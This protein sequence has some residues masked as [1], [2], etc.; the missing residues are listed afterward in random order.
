MQLCMRRKGSKHSLVCNSS[1]ASRLVPGRSKADASCAEEQNRQIGGTQSDRTTHEQVPCWPQRLCCL[2]RARPYR[3]RSAQSSALSLPRSPR[4]PD[5]RYLARGSAASVHPCLSRDDERS[6]AICI[7]SCIPAAEAAR[8][9]GG[10]FCTNEDV[11]GGTAS[12]RRIE[13]RTGSR[14]LFCALARAA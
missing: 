11:R 12:L 7:C 13:P 10:A 3:R 14:T 6:R 9:G 5:R 2:T 1:Q 4:I 8:P